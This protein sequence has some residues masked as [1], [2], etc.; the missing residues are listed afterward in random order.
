MGAFLIISYANPPTFSGHLQGSGSNARQTL[1]SEPN[2]KRFDKCIVGWLG[3]PGEVDRGA[4]LVDP[5]IQVPH[6]KLSALLRNPT[7][8]PTLRGTSTTSTPQKEKRSAGEKRENVPTILNRGSLQ[9][10]DS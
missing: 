4:G 5:W 2:T 3:R 1:C 7:C 9:R 8:R 6:H 10:V